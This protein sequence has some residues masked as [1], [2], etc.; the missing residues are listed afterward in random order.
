MIDIHDIRGPIIIDQSLPWW[1][2][3]LIVLGGGLLLS[4]VLWWWR[5]RA[6][7]QSSRTPYEEAL[8]A[9]SQAKAGIG[10]LSD[11]E[12]C[13]LVSDT[14]RGYLERVLSLPVLEY[15]TEEFLEDARSGGLLDASL[16]PVLEPFLIQCDEVKFA[17]QELE[18]V[19]REALRNSAL[20]VI[21]YVHERSNQSQKEDA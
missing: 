6:V 3:L 15:T 21:K 11:K 17:Q 13:S 16:L 2:W 5:R 9:L 1:G 19:Q 18:L 12:Y 8:E 20:G 4:A 7:V 10:K 14:L